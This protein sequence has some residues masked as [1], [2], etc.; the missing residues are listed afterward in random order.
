MIQSVSVSLNPRDLEDF[1]KVR[2]E[3]EARIIKDKINFLEQR[4]YKVVLNNTGSLEDRN[5]KMIK[6]LEANGYVVKKGK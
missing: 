6:V 4:G 5:D 1:K 2:D 3:T